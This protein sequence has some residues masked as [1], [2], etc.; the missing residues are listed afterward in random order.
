VE[1][2]ERL[3]R[4]D[5]LG[6]WSNLLIAVG[7]AVSEQRTYD[8]QIDDVAGRLLEVSPP[9]E[10]AA[11]VHWGSLLRGK[12]LARAWEQVAAAGTGGGARDPVD[13]LQQRL[14]DEW[15]A[16][17]RLAGT[18][19]SDLPADM[20]TSQLV[21][22]RITSFVPTIRGRPEAA[23]L[24]GELAQLPHQMAAYQFAADGDLE[25][26]VLLDRLWLQLLAWDHDLLFRDSA[27]AET[28]AEVTKHDAAARHLLDQ[29]RLSQAAQLRMWYLKLK[30]EL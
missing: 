17:A 13:R 4:L 22:V 10:P 15:L 9:G 18:A 20:A 26:T 11:N 3:A 2:Q 27:G 23:E 5:G 12:L 28:V 24:S 8:E 16:Q 21:A 7:H 25:R 30:R 14:Q 6:R 1:H 29:L 19:D